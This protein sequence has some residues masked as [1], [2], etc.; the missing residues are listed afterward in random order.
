MN[1]VVDRIELANGVTLPF[2]ELG[3]RTG[4]PVIFLHGITDTWRS[5][6]PV[7]PHLS[8]ANRIIGVTQRGH[9]EA[10]RPESGYEPANFANDVALLMDALGIPAAVLAGSSMGS[11]VA[12]KFAANY[13]ERTL[14]LALMGAFYPVPDKPTMRELWYDIVAPLE[15][16]VDPAI[17]EAFQ[18]STVARPV[19]PGLME[20]MIAEC[21]Q[22]PAW[23][24]KAATWP[25]VTM[26]FAGQLSRVT[27]PVRLLWG[28]RDAMA[29]QSDQ[30]QL[31]QVLPKATLS[32]YPGSGHA[33]HWELPEL[34]AEEI[35]EF[36]AGIVR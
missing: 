9:G 28:D 30:A 12:L 25:L 34:V 19:A 21:L 33:M 29:L 14:G 20:T 31:L 3:D 17:A 18:V 16:T 1:L 5:F 11:I 4:T 13:P 26:D 24:W 36:V 35:D 8:T 22:A 27:A 7:F 23:V 2:V 6:E 10:S 15:D 32:V